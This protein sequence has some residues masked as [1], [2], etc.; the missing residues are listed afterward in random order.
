MPPNWERKIDP[1]GRAYYVN[2]ATQVVQWDPPAGAAPAPAPS[3]I[4][5]LVGAF[6]TAKGLVSAPHLNGLHGVVQSSDATRV[7]V[8]F[9]HDGEVKRLKRSNLSVRA[10]GGVMPSQ[11]K[12]GKKAGRSSRKGKSGIA[13]DSWTPSKGE[14][15]KHAATAS[16]FVSQIDE[17]L[18]QSGQP[19]AMRVG[20]MRHGYNN[21]D[22]YPGAISPTWTTHAMQQDID[23][24][25]LRA[26]AKRHVQPMSGAIVQMGSQLDRVI[27][28]SP[29]ER[30][31]SPVCEARSTRKKCCCCGERRL[32]S[33]T[34]VTARGVPAASLWLSRKGKAAR[35][36]C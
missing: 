33:G 8:R 4:S 18:A 5:F 17:C 12:G 9:D 7:D 20:M 34:S 29:M 30:S 10:S 2:H 15:D 32:R 16:K 35:P 27:R 19:K 26:E 6:V 25:T 11:A 13:T 24:S 14:Q 28:G 22:Y 36:P 23:A 21:S 3:A 31:L 1:T